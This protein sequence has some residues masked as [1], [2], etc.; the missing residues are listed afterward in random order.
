M[1]LLK[2][3]ELFRRLRYMFSRPIRPNDKPKSVENKTTRL[4]ESDYDGMGNFSRF[5]NPPK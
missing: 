2:R 3:I 1:E 4:P 5:G